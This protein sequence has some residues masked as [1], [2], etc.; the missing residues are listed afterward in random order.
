[1]KLDL[2]VDFVSSRCGKYFPLFR[3]NRHLFPL[4]EFR[5]HL[6]RRGIRIRFLTL[7]EL[8]ELSAGQALCLDSRVF[9]YSDG[10]LCTKHLNLL[11]RLG[12]NYETVIWFDNRDSSGTTQF[13]V[14][15]YVDR[16]CK[17][18]YLRNRDL[19][20][21]MLYGGRI[22]TD[23]IH[24]TYG[25]VDSNV[26]SCGVPLDPKH[27]G[28]L[29]LSWNLA[30]SHFRT[31]TG[32]RAW[33]SLV[34]GSRSPN[35]HQY[36]RTDRPIDVQARYTTS[37]DSD[38]VEFHRRS[39]LSTLEELD[40]IAYRVGRVSRNEYYEEMARSRAV[41]SP[42]GW[43]EICY[44]DFEAMLFGCALLKPSLRHLETWPDLLREGETYVALPWD[45]DAARGRMEEVL[46][47]HSLLAYVAANA[48]DKF[49]GLWD[50]QA[51]ERFCDHFAA[52]LT[53]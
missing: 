13:E 34:V 24:R 18:Q 36:E 33:L 52:I 38:V 49:R 21:R 32:L 8:S 1:M 51:A 29:T 46:S 10:T 22:Y 2:H 26:D 43:G 17:K 20:R 50:Q 42:F 7:Q 6:A 15:P 35:L 39:L 9:R 3:R 31:S 12:S 16:Y 41:L 37:Y 23:A 14:L 53:S 44:R 47:N 28:K 11:E 48:Q 25:I 4:F 19:Y 5:E 27:E 45:A 30:Y 40:G